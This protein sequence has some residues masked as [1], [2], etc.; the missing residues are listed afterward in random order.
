MNILESPKDRAFV[1][2]IWRL[3]S[4]LGIKV[5]AEHVENAEVL[6]TLR[7]IGIDMAQGY[8]IGRPERELGSKMRFAMQS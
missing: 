6:E 7:E 1:E 4:D 2:T 8:Y 5:I 3:A